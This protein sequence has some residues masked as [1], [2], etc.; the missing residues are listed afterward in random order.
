VLGSRGYTSSLG[1]TDSGLLVIGGGIF[2]PA[3]LVI[4][5][6]GRLLGGGQVAHAVSNSGLIEASS[7]VLAIASK[8]TGTGVENRQRRNALDHQ[9]S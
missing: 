4:T 2:S 3:S 6:G 1:L 9:H 8:I 7:G 5:A